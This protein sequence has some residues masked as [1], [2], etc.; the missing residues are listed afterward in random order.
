MMSLSVGRNREEAFC[1]L[2]WQLTKVAAM[3]DMPLPSFDPY[4][5]SGSST[6]FLGCKENSFHKAKLEESFLQN[7]EES[8]SPKH[9]GAYDSVFPGRHPPESL[10][11]YECRCL[12]LHKVT[13]DKKRQVVRD[14]SMQWSDLLCEPGFSERIAIKEDDEIVGVR[15]TSW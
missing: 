14:G 10:S 9:A 6:M 15:G 1:V 4:R 8:F 5:F 7:M 11:K 13:G 3:A 12:F 2:A